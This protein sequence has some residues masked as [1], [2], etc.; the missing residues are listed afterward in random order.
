M[1]DTHRDDDALVLTGTPALHLS[2]RLDRAR[3][4]HREPPGCDKRRRPCFAG[5]SPF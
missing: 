5:P 3:M 4:V 2:Q 1:R